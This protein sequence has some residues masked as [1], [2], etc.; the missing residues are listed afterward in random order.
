[1]KKR[2]LALIFTAVCGF[3]GFAQVLD[4]PG[5]QNY[6]WTGMGLPTGTPNS[7]ERNG[8]RWYG[9]IDTIQA[10]VD[11]SMF[12]I[13]G[14]LSWGA[15]TEWTENDINDFTFIN[16]HKNPSYFLHQGTARVPDTGRRSHAYNGGYV[17]DS[18]YLNFLIHAF[19]GFDFGMG[20][21]L[22]WSVG[23]NPSYGAYEWEYKSHVH[24]GDLRDGAPGT[25]P[26][27]GYLKYANTYAQKALAARYKYKDMFEIGFSIP[28]GFTTHAPATN[29][30]VE[31][32]PIPFITAAFAYEGLFMS[33]S[34]LYTGATLRFTKNFVIDAY[35]AF[36][37]L[38]NN[39]SNTGRWGSGAAILLS[40]PKI[41]L[42]VRPEVGFTDYVNSDYTFALYTGGK[43]N[44][45]IT[46]AC[47]L[48]CWVSF[49]WGAENSKWHDN[50]EVQYAVTKDWNGG[51][52]FNIR[53]E[54][55][56]DIN[57][58]H[59]ISVTTEFQSI[60]NYR[61]DIVDSLLFGFYW[62]YRS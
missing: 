7:S 17:D 41:S 36:D 12:T 29:I 1:M 5:V 47:H 32:T 61:R 43:L 24:Q 9:F 53:P 51:F 46:K 52:I 19:S 14:M 48:G 20:T 45:D 59:T 34:N 40:F 26:V 4:K 23:P 56:F 10:R 54:F 58:K 49:A 37:N 11:I 13:D 15:L 60:T 21:R 27:A 31:I 28:S 30:G 3:A 35:F 25:V 55:S 2:L 18:Y 42:S 38:G 39:Y 16:T 62:R 6:L 57:S 44:F 22:E 8:F 33:D 50:T